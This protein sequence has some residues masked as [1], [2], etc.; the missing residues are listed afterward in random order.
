MSALGVTR[1]RPTWNPARMRQ[2]QDPQLE[3]AIAVILDLLEK[4]PPP[5]FERPPYP[6]YEQRL[7]GEQGS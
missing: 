1:L 5:T 6:D 2:G 4:N 7:P 3:K